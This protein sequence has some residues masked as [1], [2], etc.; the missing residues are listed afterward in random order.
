VFEKVL[1]ATDGSPSADRALEQ[2]RALAKVGGGSVV[3]VHCEEMT[4]PGKGGGSLPVNAAEESVTGK[5]ERQVG[6]LSGDGVDAKLELTRA[7]V[8]GAAH[9]I[10]EIA[11][12]ENADVI[13][14]GNRGHTALAGLLLGSVPQRL[15][16]ISTVPVLVVPPS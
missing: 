15:L 2:A 1:W 10:V 7:K 4:L 5:I 11:T 16:H 6:E 14:V 8:G 9:T 12:R 3:V 13:V